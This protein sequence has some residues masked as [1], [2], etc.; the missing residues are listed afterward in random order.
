MEKH[1]IDGAELLRRHHS[2]DWG[3]CCEE[4]KVH[5]DRALEHGGRLMSVY[6]FGDDAIW[7]ITEYDYSATTVLLPSEY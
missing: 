1:E 7:I 6:K 4:D 5:N 3:D 2:G